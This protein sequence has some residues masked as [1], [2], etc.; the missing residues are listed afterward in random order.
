MLNILER[1][2]LKAA[3]RYSATTHHLTM[4]AMRRAY[5]DRASWLGDP[6]FAPQPVQRLTS[7]AYVD[8]LAASIYPQR[9]TARVHLGPNVACPPSEH[10]QATHSSLVAR[11]GH[12]VTNTYTMNC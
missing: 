1:F 6:D 10:R 7:K 12:T 3:G 2:D 9:A 4:E 11:A 5:L 8:S